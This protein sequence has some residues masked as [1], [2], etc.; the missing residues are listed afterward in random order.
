M[1]PQRIAQLVP[2]VTGKLL[3]RAVHDWKKRDITDR[4]SK[5]I[6]AVENRK[7]IANALDR[8]AIALGR[9]YR[10]LVEAIG[11]LLASRLIRPKSST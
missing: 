10:P 9:D 5:V 8:Q 2:Y 7:F 1:G 6:V 3:C 11:Y 4:E